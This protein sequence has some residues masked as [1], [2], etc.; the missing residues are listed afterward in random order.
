MSLFLATGDRLVIAADLSRRSLEVGAAAARRFGI[1]RVLFV[2]TD[3]RAPGLKMGAFDLV[4]TSGVLHHTPNPRLSFASVAK[5]VKPG[6]FVV[7][8][9][10]NAAARLPHRLRRAVARLTGYRRV[11]FDPVLRE[12]SQPARRAAWLR[13]QYQHPEEHRHTLG[14]VRAWF[15]ENGVKY[16]RCYPSVLIGGSS[17]SRSEL[18]SGEDDWWVERLLAQASW[19]RSLSS[20][21]GLFLAIGTRP[22]DSER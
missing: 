20:E 3:L 8:G 22:V 19:M 10:Y 21:G 2:E 11:P 16:L 9:V 15:Q 5:L 13:D 14:E 1:D 18:F 12:R 7:L 4:Y 17:D 6:G